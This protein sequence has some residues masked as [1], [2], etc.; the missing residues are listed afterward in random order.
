MNVFSK[1]R[2]LLRWRCARMRADEALVCTGQRHYVIRG[3]RRS[4]FVISRH[5]FR[6]LKRK[7]YIRRDASVAELESQCFYATPYPDGS[8][9]MTR[10]VLRLKK[11]MFLQWWQEHRKG[12]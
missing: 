4:L 11:A 10:A 3:A 6:N 12:Q 8:R 2:A 7:H 9:R 1:F 5:D